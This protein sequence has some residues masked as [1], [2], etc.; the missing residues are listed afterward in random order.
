[1]SKKKLAIGV[2][3]SHGGTNLQTIIDSCNDGRLDA[4]MRVVICN[5]S[6]ATA[7]ERARREGIPCFHMSGKTHPD[8]DELDSAITSTLAEHGVDLV[9]LAG[10]VVNILLSEGSD[11]A[12][13]DCNANQTPDE[14]DIQ[15]GESQDDDGDGVPDECATCDGDA[16]G[17]GTVDPLDVGFVLARFGCPVGT[18]DPTCDTADQNGDG[19]VDPLDSGFVLARFGPCDE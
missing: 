19:I 3:S 2:L 4:E 17:D 9:V 16:N 13:D 12:S 6:H 18:G 5:N 10:A 8:A 11:A 15:S 14:C 1:M 7:M